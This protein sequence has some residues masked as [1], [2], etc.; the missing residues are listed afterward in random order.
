MLAIREERTVPL[1]DVVKPL[2]LVRQLG[3]FKAKRTG[4]SVGTGPHHPRKTGPCVQGRVKAT[5]ASDK[6]SSVILGWP[7]A[8]MTT[9]CLPEAERYVMGVA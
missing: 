8:A 6:D 1:K 3:G 7:P 5:R 2:P 4:L 9:N